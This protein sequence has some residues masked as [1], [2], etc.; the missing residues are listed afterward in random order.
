MEKA[1]EITGYEMYV[2][3]SSIMSLLLNYHHLYWICNLVCQDSKEKK[4]G[5]I[6]LVI[7]CKSNFIWPGYYI[8][9]L[10]SME[11]HI[12]VSNN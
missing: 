1:K 2:F 12:T 4:T 9:V 10:P 8:S 3:L 11:I 5:I 6:S 7:T